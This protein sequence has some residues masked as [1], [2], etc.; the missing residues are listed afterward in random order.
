MTPVLSELE[1]GTVWLVGAGPGDPGLLTLHAYQALQQAEVVVYDAL[2]AQP[3]LDLVNPAAVLEFA[4][5]RAGNHACTQAEIA[6]RLI[7]LAQQGKRV[8]RLKG[9]DPFVFGRGGEEALALVAAGISFRVVPGITSGL[10]ALAA[11]GIPATTRATNSAI[12]FATGHFA[13]N[14]IHDEKLRGLAKS[15]HPLVLY[16][17]VKSLGAV[18]NVLIEGGL[19]PDT[20]VAIISNATTARQKIVDTRLDSAHSDAIAANVQAPAIIAIGDIVRLR[21]MLA[22]GIGLLDTN[23][24]SVANPA[25][26]QA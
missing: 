2:I 14:G 15:G 4:G 7:A 18:A 9:G 25:L 8:V 26:V 22:E 11:A 6:E 23:E 13:D 12:T 24:D 3:I 1:P 16:M 21:P 19:A 5:K 10:A 17:A 20:P